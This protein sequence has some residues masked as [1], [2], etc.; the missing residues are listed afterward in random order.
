MFVAL[1]EVLS[2]LPV[3]TLIPSLSFVL[4]NLGANWPPIRKFST[5]NKLAQA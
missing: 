2:N 1:S 4:L 5:Y 3:E